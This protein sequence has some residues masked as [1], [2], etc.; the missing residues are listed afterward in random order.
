MDA[1]G[2]EGGWG[3]VTS[4][5]HQANFRK[6]LDTNAIKLKIRDTPGNFS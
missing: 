1:N 2:G 6:T 3:D 4:L 5:P